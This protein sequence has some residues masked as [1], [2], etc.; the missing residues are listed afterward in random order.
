M[1]T[2]LVAACN[3][4]DTSWVRELPN[5]FADNGWIRS[6]NNT[7][8]PL[9]REAFVYLDYICGHYSELSPKDEVVFCQGNP[10]NHDPEFI[11]H[12]K[13]KEIRHYGRVVECD[14]MSKP[15]WE[16]DLHT[17]CDVLKLPLRDEYKFVAGAQYRLTGAQIKLRERDFYYALIYLTM[18][19]NNKSAYVLERLWP[20]I[21]EL[22]L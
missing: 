14:R 4:E 20:V 3:N 5:A 21:W 22:S 15:H 7:K 6:I 2:I 19:P 1:N 13:D 16:H 12:V 10:F 18:I 9:G 8:N 17:W 11:E